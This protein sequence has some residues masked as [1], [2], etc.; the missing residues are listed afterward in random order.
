MTL[1]LSPVETEQ[2]RQNVAAW[3]ALL[4]IVANAPE[5]IGKVQP[6]AH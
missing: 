3:T 2:L 1:A 5:D 4:A 6:A